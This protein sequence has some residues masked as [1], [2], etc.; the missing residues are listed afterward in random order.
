M[1]C[2]LTLCCVGEAKALLFFVGV[3]EKSGLCDIQSGLEVYRIQ[4]NMVLVQV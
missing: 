4:I 3:R 1:E 2:R